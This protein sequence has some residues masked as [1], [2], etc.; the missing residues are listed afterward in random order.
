MSSL[1]FIIVGTVFFLAGF[2]TK[3]FVNRAEFENTGCYQYETNP[4]PDDILTNDLITNKNQ[5]DQK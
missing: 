2:N 1:T 5:A 4:A 3:E